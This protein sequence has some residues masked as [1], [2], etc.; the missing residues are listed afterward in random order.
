MKNALLAAAITLIIFGGIG[1]LVMA[2]MVKPL[3]AGGVIVFVTM[4]ILYMLIYKIL[5]KDKKDNDAN[6]EDF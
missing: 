4:A 1:V 3:I 5:K 2:L 6:C